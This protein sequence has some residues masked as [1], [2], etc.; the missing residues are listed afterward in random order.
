M[1]VTNNKTFT[2]EKLSLINFTDDNDNKSN[3]YTQ[4]GVLE[5]T[6]IQ[7]LIRKNNDEQ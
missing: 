1:S 3:T 4:K 5:I 6:N 7:I 2:E